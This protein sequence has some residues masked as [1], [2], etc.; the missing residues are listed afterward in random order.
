[1][2]AIAYAF[3]VG[4]AGLHAHAAE[5][6]RAAVPCLRAGASTALFSSSFGDV[7]VLHSADDILITPLFSVL[8]LFGIGVLLGSVGGVACLIINVI[9]LIE[10]YEVL[11]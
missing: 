2:H 6:V 1:M 11:H 8:C 5:R 9:V 10:E 4:L 3:A 7:A